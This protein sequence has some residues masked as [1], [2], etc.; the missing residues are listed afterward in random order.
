MLRTEHRQV[1]IIHE[2]AAVREIAQN[3]RSPEPCAPPVRSAIAQLLESKLGPTP[4]VELFNWAHVQA[5]ADR[6]KM[7][8]RDA[9]YELIRLCALIGRYCRTTI[10]NPA[11]PA[12]HFDAVAIADR[13]ETLADFLEA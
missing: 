10:D 3:L 2:L 8:L 5:D 6:G 11:D 1:S 7:P 13:L 12:E 4:F 9:L